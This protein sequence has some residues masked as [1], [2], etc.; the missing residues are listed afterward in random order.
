MA[1][2][3]PEFR[4][5]TGALEAAKAFG[6]EIRGKIVVITGIS[7]QSIGAAL[8]LA[9]ASQTPKLLI[10]ASRTLSN[11]QKVAKEIHALY[12]TVR[13][14]EVVLDLSNLKSVRQAAENVKQIIGL[15]AAVDI[16]F[17]NAG[18]NISTKHLTAEG[19]ELQFATNHLGPF[20]F[21]NLLL[22]SMLQAKNGRKRVVNTASEAHVISP[23]RFSDINQHRG[24]NVS[25]DEQPRRGLPEGILRNDGSYES[26]IA[27]GQSKT[28][29]VLFSVGLNAR[30]A[31]QGLRSFAVSP[32]NIMTNLAREFD[33]AAVKRLFAGIGD[34]W[35]TLDQGASTL[36]VAGFDPGLDDEA[37]VYV[38]DCKVKRPAKWASDGAKAE[39]LWELSEDLVSEKFS[40]TKVSRL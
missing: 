3:H 2:S 27:Y 1:I 23:V 9:V 19:V 28:A 13:I 22:P 14:E 17:N 10:L 39:R 12:P 21:T 24:K 40:P 6:G 31:S 33:E 38:E 16:L 32:G 36:V 37:G 25:K 15:D 7:P 30:Y 20:L 34:N 26:G 8:A 11:I 29:N 5:G 4:H 18:I 35:K